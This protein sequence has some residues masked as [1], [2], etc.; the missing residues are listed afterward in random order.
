VPAALTWVRRT[1]RQLD[2]APGLVGRAVAIDLSPALW[3][4][5][6]WTDR[7][8]LL[9]FEGSAAHLAAQTALRPR[10]LPAT[11]A[12]WT[13]PT[14]GLPITWAEV[15]RRIAVAAQAT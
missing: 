11:F 12:V 4:V 15:R 9:R 8:D 1:R 3:I 7:N 2:R 6:A 14:A 10:L 5:S 13:C